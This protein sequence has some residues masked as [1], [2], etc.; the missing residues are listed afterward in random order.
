MRKPI[1]A[2]Q[3]P[4]VRRTAGVH[5]FL[6]VVMLLTASSIILSG[7]SQLSKQASFE[8]IPQPQ[9]LAQRQQTQQPPVNDI[10]DRQDEVRLAQ[11]LADEAA[12]L[13]NELESR[14]QDIVA[15]AA[16]RAEY[17]ESDFQ[18]AQVSYEIEADTDT[19][20]M[21]EEASNQ[22]PTDEDSA[23]EAPSEAKESDAI[24][25]TEPAPQPAATGTNSIKLLANADDMEGVPVNFARDDIDFS[26]ANFLRPSNT[27]DE[28]TSELAED[29]L[30]GESPLTPFG[31][32]DSL[33]LPLQP[34]LFNPSTRTKKS[35]LEGTLRPMQTASEEIEADVIVDRILDAAPTNTGSVADNSFNPLGSFGPL[36]PLRKEDSASGL[37]AVTSAT[38]I[39]SVAANRLLSPIA[40]DSAETASPP[41]M[42]TSPAMETPAVESAAPETASESTTESTTEVVDNETSTPEVT[43]APAPPEPIFVSEEIIVV[44]AVE[45]PATAPEMTPATAMEV[46][47]TNVEPNVQAEVPEHD[48]P[49]QP[50]VDESL[51]QTSAS[52]LVARTQESE[53]AEAYIPAEIIE[54]AIAVA[55]DVQRELTAMT[56]PTA[57]TTPPESNNDFKIQAVS[58]TTVSSVCAGCGSESC[59]GCEHDVIDDAENGEPL[60]TNNDFAAP[61]T[62]GG[63]F[64]AP[65]AIPPAVIPDAVP[66]KIIA[67]SSEFGQP[68]DL[69][70]PPETDPAVAHVA[71]L[72]ISSRTID[73]GTST[74]NV[75]PVGISTLMELN[76]VTWK[77]RLDE[78]IE[79]A[80]VRL[81]RMNQPS[82]A[83]VVNLRL[84][85]A[86]R[87]Q[88]EQV[89]A[90][91]GTA[92]YSENESQYWQHQLEAIT[93]ML[94]ST[95]GE[96][97]AVTDYHRH[98]TAHETLEHLRSAVA[99][100]ESIASL[101]V[102][103]GQF[104]TEITG[105]GQFRTFPSTTFSAGQKMLVYCEVENHKT[106]ESQTATGNDFRTRLRGSFAIYNA[107]GKV[108]QQAEF[109]TVDDVA[110]K[111]RRDFYMYMPVT[112]GDL[113]AGQYVLHALVEDI[114]G[115]KTASL[116]PPLKFRVE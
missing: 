98:Q 90:S 22:E 78:A 6:L 61:A 44:D 69:Q 18:I 20:D 16:E 9:S 107:N 45:E 1:T 35:I 29:E 5:Y 96:N 10:L 85:K 19:D 37:S 21:V 80:E 26:T 24:A 2:R 84:L 42:E 108:V 105:F 8:P 116:D 13:E 11:Q 57:E 115:N 76:A 111:R 47:Q 104:C 62:P 3:N 71:A 113:P 14:Q 72:P 30:A 32:A 59:A 93:T 25:G 58:N 101:K 87:G 12:E 89:E 56:I 94:S 39:A 55:E 73:S 64:V 97:Q 82:D 17:T 102:T 109:P 92:D 67:A 15:D 34:M 112:L 4:S 63:D 40:R 70:A 52:Y 88:M 43:P 46:A 103:S 91:P 7:C 53:A 28:S 81:N 60:F 51:A 110:R 50:V 83:S 74:S 41:T 48:F 27:S 49:G 23:S 66:D 65:M 68:V 100:L 99:Q 79:L 106:I 38:D 54:D 114:Y 77:S 75:P 86:L 36:A 31:D 33:L 95:A